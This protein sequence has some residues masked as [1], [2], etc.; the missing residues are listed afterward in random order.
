ML[1]AQVFPQRDPVDLLVPSALMSKDDPRCLSIEAPATE[2][3]AAAPLK[4][5]T[6]LTFVLGSDALE[7]NAGMNYVLLCVGQPVEGCADIK[8]RR[9]L[10]FEALFRQRYLDAR[11][12]EAERLRLVQE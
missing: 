6:G 10:R 3:T 4:T 5:T 9:P 2:E 7:T 1:S 11:R 8:G 12:G